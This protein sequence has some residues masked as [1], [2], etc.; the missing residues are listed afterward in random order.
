M[1]TYIHNV[2]IQEQEGCP[3]AC[4]P[5]EMAHNDSMQGGGVRGGRGRGGGWGQDAIGYAEKRAGGGR[6]RG[7]GGGGQGSLVMKLHRSCSAYTPGRKFECVCVCGTKIFASVS[8]YLYL[9][10]CLA[11]CM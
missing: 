1:H 2:C 11:I 3:T 10:L 7:G 6:V 8:I 4:S 5:T 9:S